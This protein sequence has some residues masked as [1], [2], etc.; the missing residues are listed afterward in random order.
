MSGPDNKFCPECS[1]YSSDHDHFDFYEKYGIIACDGIPHASGEFPYNSPPH[2][3]TSEPLKTREEIRQDKI[4]KV[5][6]I[7]KEKTIE[8]AAEY[9]VDYFTL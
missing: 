5:A 2:C 7:I 1:Q 6:K 9:I 3:F 4:S 8:E